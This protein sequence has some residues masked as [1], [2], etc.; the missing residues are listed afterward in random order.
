MIV[1]MTTHTHTHSHTHTPSGKHMPVIDR[2]CYHVINVA[3]NRLMDTKLLVPLVVCASCFVT[4]F[5]R[6]SAHPTN[7]HRND[8]VFAHCKVA[9]IELL[10]F[11][12]VLKIW[13]MID[14]PLVVVH[15]RWLIVV[16]R[17]RN[18]VI[19][20]YRM[21]VWPNWYQVHPFESAKR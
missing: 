16:G 9:R 12:N 4:L 3:T 21:N 14:G 8:N 15:C 19:K 1:W 18:D 17:M 13:L 2:L 11:R 7:D 5:F 10:S 6:L 20:T